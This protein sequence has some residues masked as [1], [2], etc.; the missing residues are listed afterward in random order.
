MGSRNDPVWL[1]AGEVV[2]L[3][4]NWRDAV[5]LTVGYALIIATLWT[6]RPAQ[7]WLYWAAILW[8]AGSTWISFPGWRAMGFRKKGF[9]RGLWV[10]AA[11]LGV[12][13]A[14]HLAAIHLHTLRQP[15][16][17]RE[18]LLMFGGYTVWSFVQQ[19]LLQGY[20][21]YRL[22]RLLPRREWAAIAAATIFAAA[23]IPNP[24]LTP[25]TLVWGLCA[26]FAFL[27]THNIY[28]LAIAHAIL[29]ITLAVTVPGP[30]VRNMRVGLGYLHYRAPALP[31]VPLRPP[32]L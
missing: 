10:T 13:I 5:E 6:P 19:F 20:F 7:R 3:R 2:P 23:H 14:A 12:A 17:A 31:S 28:P 8:I 25:L 15:Y 22:L 4:R 21:L 24:V 18:W 26:C 27:R 16:G 29:G 1:R 9:V 11:A 32:Q 30:V